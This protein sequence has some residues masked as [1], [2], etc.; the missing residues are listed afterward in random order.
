MSTLAKRDWTDI[1][2]P[3]VTDWPASL[4]D[5]KRISLPHESIN[6]V[7]HLSVLQPW[8]TLKSRWHLRKMIMTTKMPQKEAA[9]TGA[10]R[11][12]P[13][14]VSQ[15]KQLK[16][17]VCW[18]T[19]SET[20]LTR[21]QRPWQISFVLKKSPDENLRPVSTHLFYFKIEKH[22][23]YFCC[24]EET[25]TDLKS[26]ADDPG[27]PACASLCLMHTP[28]VLNCVHFCMHLFL[29]HFFL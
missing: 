23:F 5:L 17:Y 7:P 3:S 6:A 14:T 20:S 1:E 2:A 10:L 18:V 11:D 29:S 21:P 28:C 4:G 25:K 13:E 22:L 9:R 12:Y 19:C 16:Y 27:D 8:L 26:A 15:G 24:V